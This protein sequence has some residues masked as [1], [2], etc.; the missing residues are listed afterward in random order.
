MY[1]VRRYA[2]HQIVRSEEHLIYMR[3]AMISKGRCNRDGGYASREHDDTN[4]RDMLQNKIAVI[5]QWRQELLSIQQE[6]RV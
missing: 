4:E 3:V 1:S 5:S 2:M 6:C